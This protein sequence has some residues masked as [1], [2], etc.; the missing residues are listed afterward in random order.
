MKFMWFSIFTKHLLPYVS[1]MYLVQHI[2]AICPTDLCTRWRI[3]IQSISLI[4]NFAKSPV[5]WFFLKMTYWPTF[6][7]ILLTNLLYYDYKC[8]CFIN[9]LTGYYGI[10]GALIQGI[11]K[12]KWSILKKMAPQKLVCWTATWLWCFTSKIR[13][14]LGALAHASFWNK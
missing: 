14:P 12:K 3:E 4:T 1:K 8:L 2:L 6:I 5:I 7:K 9:L 10:Y 11:M 13:L